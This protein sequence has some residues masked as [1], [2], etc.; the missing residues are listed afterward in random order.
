MAHSENDNYENEH[1]IHNQDKWTIDID[2]ILDSIRHNSILLS[3][4]H[5]TQYFLLQKN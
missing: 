1:L 2:L 3:E 5:R 4:Y